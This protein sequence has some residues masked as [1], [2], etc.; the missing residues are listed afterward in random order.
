MA[1]DD[2]S[3]IEKQIVEVRNLFVRIFNK[4]IKSGKKI[5]EWPISSAQLKALSA[6]HE[7]REYSMG[8]L[9]RNALVT[10]PSMTE[11]VDRL[12]AEGVLERVRD[13]RDRRVV[14]VHLT[15]KGKQLH[16]SFIDGRK[17]DMFKV[18]GRLDRMD[19]DELVQ[20]LKKVSTIL[21]KLGI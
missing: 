6:F 10:M 9:S 11:M 17:Q 14:K 7:D 20:A 16:K 18:F 19:R 5:V 15:A 4:M 8:E 3:E 13:S 1:M 12:E 21:K 2:V